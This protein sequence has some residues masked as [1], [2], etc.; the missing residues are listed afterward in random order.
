MGS[1]HIT[2]RYFHYMIISKLSEEYVLCDLEIAK[3]IKT[4]HGP[5]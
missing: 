4:S 2:L 1:K 5:L 3:A